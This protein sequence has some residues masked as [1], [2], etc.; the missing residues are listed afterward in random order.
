MSKYRITVDH[1]KCI[2]C[3]ACEQNCDNFKLTNGKSSP[4]KS[5][6]DDLTKN[7][8]VDELTAPE[9]S[10]FDK[11]LKEQSIIQ[12]EKAKIKNNN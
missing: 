12:D 4:I 6:I 8:K 5:E 2:G 7:T 10:A 1:D 3:G 11:L 9:K